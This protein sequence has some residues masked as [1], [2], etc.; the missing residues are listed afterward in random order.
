M[1]T[2]S[3][4]FLGTY[5]TTFTATITDTNVSYFNTNGGASGNYVYGETITGSSSGTTAEFVGQNNLQVAY[6]NMVGS[7]FTALETVTGSTSGV[8]SISLGAGFSAVDTFSVT[9]GTTTLYQ[10]ALTGT[11]REQLDGITTNFTSDLGHTAGD[12]WEWIYSSSSVGTATLIHQELG[13]ALA[14]QFYSGVTGTPETAAYVVGTTSGE[15]SELN[16]YFPLSTFTNGESVISISADNVTATGT[17]TSVPGADNYI[18]SAASGFDQYVILANADYTKF[19]GIIASTSTPLNA[20]AQAGFVTSDD[21]LG[22]GENGSGILFKNTDNGDYG[23]SGILNEGGIAGVIR[24]NQEG[25]T[26]TLDLSKT[27]LVFNL[28]N[29]LVTSNFAIDTEQISLYVTNPS[30]SSTIGISAN[31]IAETMQIGGG[32]SRID[33][34]NNQDKLILRGNNGYDPVKI[35]LD[36][37]TNKINFFDKYT[38]PNSSG[39]SG[40]VLALDGSGDLQWTTPSVSTS[41]ITIGTSG[42][43]LYSS[44]LSGTG[45]GDTSLGQNIFLGT[46]AGNGSTATSLSVFLGWSAGFGVNDASYSNFIGAGAGSGADDA[47]ESNIIGYGAGQNAAFASNMNFIGKDAGSAAASSSYSTFIGDQSGYQSNGSIYSTFLGTRSGYQASNVDYTNFIGSNAGTVTTGATYSNF[48]GNYAGANITTIQYSNFIGN[49]AGENADNAEYSNFFGYFAGRDATNADQS[50]F[51]GT[52][53]GYQ[54]TNA[55]RSVFI[56]SASGGSAADADESVF[57]GYYSGS[58]AINANNSVFIGRYSGQ[59]ATNARN[60]IFI[61][62]ATGVSDTVN[63]TLAANDFSILIGNGA[64]TGGFE[65]SIAIGGFSTNT[66]SNEFM[67]GSATRPIDTL[68]LTGSAG[69]TCVL[70][71]TVASP[72]CSSDET[73]KTDITDLSTTTLENLLKVKTVTYNWKNYPDKGSQIGFLAQDLEQ[74]FPEV[75]STAPNGF[76]TVSYG[77]MAPILVEAVRELDLK[78]TNLTNPTDPSSIAEKII[79]KLIKADRIETKELCVD[80]VCVTRDQFFQMVQ[81]FGQTPSITPPTDPTPTTLDPLTCTAPQVLNQTGDACVDPVAET[82]E[83]IPTVEEPSTPTE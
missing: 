31:A 73:L 60:S 29:G 57:A 46:S 35:T 66:A 1:L 54:G 11:S 8:T 64:S 4:D 45:Q 79:A 17:I 69:N 61:G 77:G 48:I 25:I 19:G 62:N 7:G 23:F 68:V 33:I 34:D 74:Y 42:N 59:G 78:I 30:N 27:G 12:E 20:N 83:E 72:S 65:N 3:D 37:T 58:N 16:Q 82:P 9:N 14:F 70:D 39:V 21:I 13:T 67:I 2:P 50:V 22:L 15:I 75:V 56:G 10:I 51:I 26:T 32:D 81:S 18:I 53:A 6:K 55:D 28:N 47:Q 40:Q 76:K 41:P 24:L 63:N 44:G 49:Y 38:F 43:T 71:V 80:D 52:S 5:P 36:G